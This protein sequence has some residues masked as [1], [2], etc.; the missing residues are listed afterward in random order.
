M[1]LKRSRSGAAE[2]QR[3]SSRRSAGAPAEV[4]HPGSET[5][6]RTIFENVG[7]AM[8]VIDQDMTIALA[9]SEFLKLFG[10]ARQAIIGAKWTEFVPTKEIEK[11]RHFCA[12]RPEGSVGQYEFAW[13]GQDGR[14]K[15]I[16]AIVSL[17]P[18]SKKYLVSFL[19]VTDQRHVEEALW[20]SE[21]NF[22]TIFERAAIGISLVDIR[23]GRILLSNPAMQELLGYSSKEL[24]G[25]RFTEFTH[26]EDAEH[27][28]SLYREMA[29]GKRTRFELKKRYIRKD[30][31][32]ICARLVASLAHG[33]SG[34]PSVIIGMIEEM[35][36]PANVRE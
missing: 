4:T 5:T 29:A 11:M 3:P 15:Q 20:E 35:A 2:R 28:I 14:T 16:A 27:Q 8:A 33:A 36:K 21:E 9:N 12:T 18:G 7:V 23:E 17:E 13:V 24:S 19:D 31:S 32:T 30:G 10:R 25:M 22:R 34:K 26:P 6:Y 1:S